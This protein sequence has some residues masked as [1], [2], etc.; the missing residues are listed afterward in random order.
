MDENAIRSLT[1]TVAGLGGAL[2]ALIGEVCNRDPE[3][4]RSLAQTLAMAITGLPDDKKA[5]PQADML[6]RAQEIAEEMLLRR[7]EKPP[8][9]PSP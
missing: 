5:S 7:G 3:L 9:R 6:Q 8:T 2:M 1:E 4:A